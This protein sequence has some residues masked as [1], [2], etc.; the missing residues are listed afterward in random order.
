MNNPKINNWE[1]IN[2][3][4]KSYPIGTKARESWSGGYWIRVLRGWK[5]CTGD[6]FTRPGGANEVLL[7][8][9]N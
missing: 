4:L 3:S 6:T 8:K 5:W 1:P 9:E 2:H 7:P